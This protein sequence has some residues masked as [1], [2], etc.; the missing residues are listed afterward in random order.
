M[1][2]N[3]Y[4]IAGPNGAG[5]TTFAR[6]FLSNYAHCPNFVNA[7]LIAQGISPLA[8]EDAAIR[9]GRLMLAEIRRLAA[10]GADFGF[11]TTLSGQTQLAV[12]K[13]L[14]AQGYTIHLFYLWLES[15]ALA[16][17]RVRIR[18]QEGGHNVPPAAI[19]R[20]YSRSLENFLRIYRECADHWALFDNS[21][22]WAV[23]VASSVEGEALILD[24]KRYERIY[25]GTKWQ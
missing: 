14:K 17:A 19:R 23:E 22:N 18:V 6:E 3:V 21:G 10:S 11:E 2:K 24:A 8:P 1:A 12:W 4:V 13:R 25:R 9:A 7:D 15:A 16:E 20:R 5:K